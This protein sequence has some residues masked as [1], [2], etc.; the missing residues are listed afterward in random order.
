M[1][2]PEL[3]LLE[4]CHNNHRGIRETLS[5]LGG[6]HTSSMELVKELERSGVLEFKYCRNGR[7]RP[8]KIVMLSQLGILILEKLR[9]ADQLMIKVNSN[10]IRSS[11]AQIRLRNRIVDSGID[12][13]DKFI[14]MNE[15]AVSIRDSAVIN[16]AP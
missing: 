5:A 15:L 13:Y 11:A 1:L 8:K 14:E 6:C 9:S 2:E 16:K 7:G 4:L 12:P 10:D 3:R